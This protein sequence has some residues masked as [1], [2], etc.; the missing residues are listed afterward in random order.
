MLPRPSHI[1]VT[2]SQRL[3]TK[4]PPFPSSVT[5]SELRSSL[6]E[7]LETSGGEVGAFMR[8]VVLS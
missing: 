2:D 3:Q 6:A 7:A 4:Q 1:A 8:V 5:T